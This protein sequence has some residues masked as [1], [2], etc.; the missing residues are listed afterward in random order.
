M[1]QS[2][3]ERLVESV[4]ALLQLF[5]VNEERYPSADG[6]IAYN[7]I[8]FQS[9][10]F[11]EDNP[12]CRG[13][14]IAAALGTA[15][16]TLQSSLD[17]LIRKGLVERGPHP[18]NKRARSHRLTNEGVKVRAAIHRQDTMNMDTLLGTLKEDEQGE[19]VRLLEKVVDRLDAGPRP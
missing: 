14:D 4:A 5:T 17:R 2:R 6:R 11:I 15:P 18:D 12:G 8:D 16:T 3:T 1:S 10:R 13:T 9:L 19:L 7:P